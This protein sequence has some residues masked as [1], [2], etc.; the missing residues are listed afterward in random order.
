MRRYLR[1]N[2]CECFFH[3]F[4]LYT[5]CFLRFVFEG[6]ETLMEELLISNARSVRFANVHGIRKILRNVIA[7]RQNLKTLSSYCPKS[8]FD[9]AREFYG[10]FALG[11]QVRFMK[12][13]TE[14][15][16][17][18]MIIRAGIAGEYQ[19]GKEVHVRRISSNAEFTVWSRS[20]DWS[21]RG[22][23]SG[24]QELQHVCYRA[25]WTRFGTYDFVIPFCPV[26][27]L[28]RR[29]DSLHIPAP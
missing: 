22:K 21:T 28:N 8:E 19:E 20:D 13:N 3:V 23:S 11:P 9:R 1:R 6:L 29:I 14:K 24:G 27:T 7:V 15:S 12:C 25:A 5:E 16:R 2:D 18:L 10:L 26:S 17:P 4:M